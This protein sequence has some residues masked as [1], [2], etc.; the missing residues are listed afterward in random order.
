VGGARGEGGGGPLGL[1]F[2]AS[3]GDGFV[4]VRA[5]I[6]WLDLLLRPGAIGGDRLPRHVPHFDGREIL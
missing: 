6:A 2:G 1:Q 3:G 4:D 5:E